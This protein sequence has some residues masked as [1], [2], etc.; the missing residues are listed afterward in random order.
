MKQHVLVK[1][2]SIFWITESML[3]YSWSIWHTFTEWYIDIIVRFFSKYG[4]S[5]SEGKS[6]C[7]LLQNILCNPLQGVICLQRKVATKDHKLVYFFAGACAA[8]SALLEKKSRRSEL[9]LYTLPRAGDSLWYIL[10]NRHFLPNIKHAEVCGFTFPLVSG[11]SH[12]G[13]QKNICCIHI[14][15]LYVPQTIFFIHTE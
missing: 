11:V 3:R 6:S 2:L 7:Y 10:V 4:S 9:A 13:W 1:F 5:V 15:L 14:Y 8:L 12:F